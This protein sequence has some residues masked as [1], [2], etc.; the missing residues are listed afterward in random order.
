MICPYHK[1]K[2][3]EN[4]SGSLSLSAFM[5]RTM[6]SEL[7]NYSG[8]I[9]AQWAS[10]QVSKQIFNFFLVCTD[11]CLK[12]IFKFKPKH[13]RKDKTFKRKIWSEF[14]H[15][16]PIFPMKEER[17]TPKRVFWAQAEVKPDLTPSRPP[18]I[19]MASEYHSHSWQGMSPMK[20]SVHRATIFN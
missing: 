4:V 1:I 3:I 13:L 12:F 10:R 15:L 7:Q 2:M 8:K 19:I 20:T 6:I 14:Q 5:V 18:E 11:T 17:Q 9:E 16:V